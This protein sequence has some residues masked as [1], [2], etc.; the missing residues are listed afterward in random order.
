[1]TR[2]PV[3][4]RPDTCR[5]D[6]R[7]DN[8]PPLGGVCPVSVRAGGV[9]PGHKKNADAESGP[10]PAF[11]KPQSVGGGPRLLDL[12]AA[13]AYLGV[14]YWTIRDWVLAEYL[15]V[16]NL[17][18]LRP[19]EGDRARKNLRRVL[20]DRPDLDAFIERQKGMGER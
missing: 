10:E 19:R 20:I 7:T 8:H 9:G 11:R 16:V 2:T 4:D 15:P 12:R 1:M 14:S 17:P 18:P 3:P 5:P 13:A 6:N